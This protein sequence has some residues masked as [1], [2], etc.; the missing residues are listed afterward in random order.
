MK[1]TPIYAAILLAAVALPAY[2]GHCPVDM[3]KIDAVLEAEPDISEEQ[4][5]E[6][7]ALRAQGEELHNAGRHDDSLAALHEAM[8]ILGIEHP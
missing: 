3:K 1:K 8:E 7:K 2:A 4:L 5:A 6:V